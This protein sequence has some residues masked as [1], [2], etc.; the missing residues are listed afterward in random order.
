MKSNKTA[1]I[2]TKTY[3]IETRMDGEV[4]GPFTDEETALAWIN[5][6]HRTGQYVIARIWER[7]MG[8][9]EAAHACGR[10]LARDEV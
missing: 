8:T 5:A 7:E 10:V 1:A 4:I 2:S 6:P 9:V 3:I